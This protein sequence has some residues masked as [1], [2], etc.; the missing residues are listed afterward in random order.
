MTAEEQLEETEGGESKTIDS[1]RVSYLPEMKA[2]YFRFS[3]FAGELYETDR[4]LIRDF[5]ASLEG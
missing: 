2:A 5:L 4:Y 1:A 3:S